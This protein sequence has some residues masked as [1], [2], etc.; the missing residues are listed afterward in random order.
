VLVDEPTKSGDI[1]IYLIDYC[2]SGRP[3]GI[4]EAEGGGLT[5]SSSRLKLLTQFKR[6]NNWFYSPFIISREMS[7]P[8]STFAVPQKLTAHTVSHHSRPRANTTLSTAASVASTSGAFKAPQHK[9]AHHLHSIP[10]REKSTRT[11]ILDHLLW[12]HARTRLQQA[13]AE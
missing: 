5:I 12:M 4:T 10:P 7:T 13:R 9:H 2:T 8:S 3:T 6:R 1:S 11:L